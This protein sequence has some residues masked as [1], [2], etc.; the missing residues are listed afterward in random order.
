SA[1]TAGVRAAGARRRRGACRGCPSRVP[2]GRRA[3]SA[4]T[5]ARVQAG[6]G[7]A[8]RKWGERA[9]RSGGGGPP[10]GARTGRSP[11]AGGRRGRL[12]G[13]RGPPRLLGA[14]LVAAP[15]EREAVRELDERALRVLA[16]ERRQVA[17]AARP[18]G[19]RRADL[20]LQRP[21]PAEE[22]CRL[23]RLAAVVE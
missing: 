3:A 18:V 16:R 2:A 23:L 7:S 1:P 12:R 20:R 9:G 4:P 5:G 13:A 10:R 22:R 17:E 21:V 6:G 14:G 15:V 19:Q 8:A 11:A